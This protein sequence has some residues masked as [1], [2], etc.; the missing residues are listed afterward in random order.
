MLGELVVI[1]ALY[2][3]YK[4]ILKAKTEFFDGYETLF[5]GITFET[6]KRNSGINETSIEKSS[7][8]PP[9]NTSLEGDSFSA[10]MDLEEDIETIRSRRKK[11]NVSAKTNSGTDWNG[12]EEEKAIMEQI[13]SRFPDINK[14]KFEKICSI[15]LQAI[16]QE[17]EK[18]DMDV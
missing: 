3:I 9:K 14:D 2:C 15:A 10:E 17:I 1:I 16:D 8:A 18:K 5:D 6:Q 4:M 12:K 7:E 11:N 13:A